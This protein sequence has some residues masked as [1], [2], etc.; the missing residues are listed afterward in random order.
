MDLGV[1]LT[2]FA[3]ILPAELPDKTFLA[4]MVLSTRYR[5]REVWAGVAAAFAVQCLI[6]VTAGRL[7][8]LLPERAVLVASATLFTLGA[9]LLLRS[10]AHADAGQQT[11]ER[12]LAALVTR[13]ASGWRASL[14]CFGVLF[15]AEW[16][17]LSQLL[18]AGL[19]ARYAN[20]VSVFVGAWTA[21]VTVAAVAVLVGRTVLR[22]ARP[23]LVRGLAGGLFGALA[24]LTWLA[25]LGV[26]S[27]LG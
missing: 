7:V 16:G 2:A 22:Y 11:E 13:A 21:L 5:G 18:T 23:A 20:P 24:V 27:P 15:A 3:L 10:A 25:A 6:A 19:A 26:A 9:V 1:A 8:A 4:T 14:V 17:D 12:E